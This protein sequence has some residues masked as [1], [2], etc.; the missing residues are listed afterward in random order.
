[1]TSFVFGCEVNLSGLPVGENSQLTVSTSTP[2]TAPR[3]LKRS[4]FKFQR[5][6]HPSR[7]LELVRSS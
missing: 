2:V 5:R 6:S 7:W 4:E 3:P 1:M